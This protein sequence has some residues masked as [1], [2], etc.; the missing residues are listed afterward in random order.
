D[1]PQTTS[2][3]SKGKGVAL[4]HSSSQGGDIPLNFQAGRV[5]ADPSVVANDNRT[6]LCGESSAP[7]VDL[8]GPSESMANH[9]I[10][11]ESSE[12]EKTTDM[13]WKQVKRRNKKKRKKQAQRA[14]A[15]AEAT[16]KAEN[17]KA[18]FGLSPLTEE[19]QVLK[20]DSGSYS[21]VPQ[22]VQHNPVSVDP[23]SLADTV[24]SSLVVEESSEDICNPSAHEESSDDDSSYSAKSS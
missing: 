22:G 6:L 12:P 11:T 15:V 1:I 17:D 14:A 21:E 3:L 13:E 24:D 9:P 19:G 23:P 4:P 20:R 16:Q 7:R 5:D 18:S 2:L 10:I 8:P